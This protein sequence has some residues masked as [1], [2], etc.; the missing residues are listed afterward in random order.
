MLLIINTTIIMEH[1]NGTIKYNLTQVIQVSQVTKKLNLAKKLLQ[2]I[3]KT[4]V[5]KKHLRLLTNQQVQQKK[6]EPL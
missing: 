3:I 4:M 6:R 2:K 1:G 5:T